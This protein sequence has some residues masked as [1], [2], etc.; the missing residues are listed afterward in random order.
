[1][2]EALKTAEHCG[3]FDRARA[4][5]AVGDQVRVPTGPLAHL[6]ARIRSTT[7]RR[8]AELIGEFAFRISAPV[9]KLVKVTA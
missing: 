3:A 1:V 8:R 7:A 4:R 2:I 9:D 6:I 5:L